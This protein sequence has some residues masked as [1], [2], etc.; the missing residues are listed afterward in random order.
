MWGTVSKIL[1]QILVKVTES[2]VQ[3]YL[4]STLKTALLKLMKRKKKDDSR[5]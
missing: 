2:C 4:E 5:E 1:I 3:W